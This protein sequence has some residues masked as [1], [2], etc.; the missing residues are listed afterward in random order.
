M[1]LHVVA[2]CAATLAVLGAMLQRKFSVTS[3]L[4]GKPTLRNSKIGAIIVKADLRNPESIHSLRNLF[5]SL[6][7]VRARIFLIEE[8]SH[9]LVSQAHALGATRVLLGPINQIGLLEKLSGVIAEDS[10]SS[11]PQAAASAGEITLASM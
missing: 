4:L 10:G 2:D 1:S 3:E 9:L 5:E 11:Q 7:D 6:S 8:T